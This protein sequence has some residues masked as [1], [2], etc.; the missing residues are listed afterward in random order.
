[1]TQNHPSLNPDDDYDDTVD[2][3]LVS[4]CYKDHDLKGIPCGNCDCMELS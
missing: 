2:P 3:E 4:G 1:M